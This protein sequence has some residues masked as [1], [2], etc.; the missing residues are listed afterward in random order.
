M[1]LHFL[2]F[3]LWKVGR[4]QH[5]WNDL[6]MPRW[7]QAVTKALMPTPPK[8]LFPLRPSSPPTVFVEIDP[9]TVSP[10]PPKETKFYGA[11]NTLAANK[12]IKTPSAIPNIEGHQTKVMKMTENAVPKPVAVPLQPTPPPQPKEVVAQSPPKKADAP[13]DLAMTKPAKKVQ[14]KEGKS[15]AEAIVQPQPQPAYQRPRTLAEAAERRHGTQGEQLRQVGGVNDIRNTSSLNV[16]GSAVGDYDAQFVAAVRQRWYQLL[17]NRTPN[18]PGKVVVEFQMHPDGRIT[19]LKVLTS[20]VT[21]L[22]SALCVQAITDPEPYQPWSK[23]MRLEIAT[24][25][26]DVQFTFYYDLE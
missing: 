2:F 20:E 16:R 11:N 19:G 4:A 18:A 22:L 12:E 15:D 17:E 7:M 14:E 26:R 10:T 1:L 23:Q 24:D 9:E 8:K 21:E 25:S 6:A 13:G 5:W 3:G